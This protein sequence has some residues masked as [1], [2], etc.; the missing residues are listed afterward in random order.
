[1]ILLVIFLPIIIFYLLNFDFKGS[2]DSTCI[3]FCQKN[4]IDKN[5]IPESWLNRY[6]I[7]LENKDDLKKDIDNDGLAL[8]EEYSNS[9]NP[10]DPDTDKDGYKD[11]KEVRDGYNPTGEGRIDLNKDNLPDFWEKE[12]GLDM[13]KNNYS[14]DNDDDGLPN[15]LE[16]AHLT[17]PLKSDTDNDG[18]SDLNEIKNGYDPVALGDAK[19]TYEIKIKKIGVVAPIIWSLNSDEDAI[20]VDLKRGVVR[21]PDTGIPGQRG[22]AVISGHSSNYAW[23]Q[24]NYN[25]IF[26]DLN[27]LVPGDEIIVRT[28]QKNNKSFEYVYKVTTKNVVVANDPVIFEEN[29]KPIITLVTCWPLRTTWKRLIIKAELQ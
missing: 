25:F 16:Y 20:E 22:N 2:V 24:G 17:N 14:L 7:K 3:S 6:D 27:N 4:N 5:E 8:L 21:Y 15:Y 29:G 9:T 11:G 28:T 26:K 18:F 23:A 13:K 1:M 19:P 12:M 10:L